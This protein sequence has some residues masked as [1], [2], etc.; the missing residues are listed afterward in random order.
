MELMTIKT[1]KN[2]PSPIKAMVL[3]LRVAVRKWNQDVETYHLHKMTFT[4]K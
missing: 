1:G 2:L 3:F 4:L